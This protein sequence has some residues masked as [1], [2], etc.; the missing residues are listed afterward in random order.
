[1]EDINVDII[2]PK[3]K[4]AT[5]IKVLFL[6]LH[7][8]LQAIFTFSIYIVSFFQSSFQLYHLVFKIQVRKALTARILIT[9][10]IGYIDIIIAMIKTVI[11]GPE[12]TSIAPL[13]I[14]T[15]SNP[16]SL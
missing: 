13:N 15:G 9:D 7:K 11:A 6:F 3:N 4:E 5:V 8:F 1:M 2:T 16:I 14:I 10:V 12:K